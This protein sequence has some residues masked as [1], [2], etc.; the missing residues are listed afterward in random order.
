VS[1]NSDIA[2]RK[3]YLK[4]LEAQIEEI[5]ER[6]NSELLALDVEI[7]QARKA[8]KDLKVDIRN[9]MHEKQDLE[10]GIEQMRE[11][12]LMQVQRF[13]TGLAYS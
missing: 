8:L 2:N 12:M 13:D 6:G 10:E 4:E 3:K 1:V 5:T 7:K 11:D 9:K